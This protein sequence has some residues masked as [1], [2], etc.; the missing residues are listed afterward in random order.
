M[1]ALHEGGQEPF[2]EDQPVLRAHAHGALPWPGREP[3]LV[4]FM[5]QR[6]YFGDEFSDHN[7]RRAR[8]P[9][10]AGDR[11]TSRVFPTTR[12]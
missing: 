1:A 3:G 8:A 12:P 2:D 11:C 6:V 4:P 9:P 5:A 10:I 7:G